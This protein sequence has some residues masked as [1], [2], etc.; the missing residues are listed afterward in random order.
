[1]NKLER[2]VIIEGIGVAALTCIKGAHEIRTGLRE[3]QEL[4][5]AG[6]AQGRSRMKSGMMPDA[7]I[8]VSGS[9]PSKKP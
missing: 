9:A 8:G 6:G 1:V 4:C 2:E 3:D 5:M 7:A